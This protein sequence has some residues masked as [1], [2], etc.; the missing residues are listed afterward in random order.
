MKKRIC[1][2][3]ILVA[4]GYLLYEYVYNAYSYYQAMTH[5]VPMAIGIEAGPVKVSLT[6]AT[7]W[8][9]VFKALVTV[10]GTYLGIRLVNKY[11]R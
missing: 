8:D 6:D 10:I 9:S 7:D 4:A 11:V 3:I 2:A 1:I 5:I